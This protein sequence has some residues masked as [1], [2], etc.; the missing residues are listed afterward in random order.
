MDIKTRYAEYTSYPNNEWIVDFESE[1]NTDPKDE[2]QTIIQAIKFALETERYKYPIM[3]SNY[4][5][6]FDDLI[7]SD[8]S[9][10]KSEIARRVRDALSTDDRIISIDNFNFTKTNG[11]D[12]I[13]S[14]NVKTIIGDAS[15]ST[16]ISV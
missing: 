3:G 1:D 5:A 9:Y 4:G 6:T 13:V 15:F 12:M 16:S 8:Y 10:I 2:L 7:G 14:F 11:S